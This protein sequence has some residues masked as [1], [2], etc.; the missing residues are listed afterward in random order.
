VEV[1]PQYR[2]PLLAIHA[3]YPSRQHLSVKVRRMVNYLAAA[4]EQPAWNPA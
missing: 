2:A 4:F 3:V 1:L